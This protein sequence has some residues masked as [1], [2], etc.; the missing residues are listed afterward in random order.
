MGPGLSL[1][2]I[3]AFGAGGG[4]AF[5]LDAGDDERC[6]T[7]KRYAVVR[8]TIIKPTVIDKLSREFQSYPLCIDLVPYTDKGHAEKHP[9]QVI[10][11]CDS[12]R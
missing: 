7:I 12:R 11:T 8:E 4:V 3:A 5:A 10:E 6:C 2:A 1:D 9:F